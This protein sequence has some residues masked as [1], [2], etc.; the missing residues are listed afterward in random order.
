[1]ANKIQVRR[2][3]KAQLTALGPLAAGEPGYTSDTK[4]LFIGNGAGSNTPV[5]TVTSANITYYVRTD[6]S[7]NNTG[8]AN[9]AAGAFRTINKAISMIP[10]IV[11]HTV[12]INVAAG[13]YA[14]A[15]LI[16]GIVGGGY[17][18]FV[19]TS[20]IIQSFRA[21]RCQRIVV[22]GFTAAIGNDVGFYAADGGAVD[23]TSCIATATSTSYGV[24]IF[25][26][27]A[28]IKNCTISNHSLAI[29]T[30]NS[31]VASRNN[32]GTGNGQGLYAMSASTLHKTGTQ[33]AAA[34]AEN[35]EGGGVIL[36]LAGVIN[37]WGDNNG[38][39]RTFVDAVSNA[40]QNIAAGVTTKML[41][42][43]ERTDSLNEYNPTLSRFVAQ[44]T[45]RYLV[46]ASVTLDMFA[47]DSWLDISIFV[48]GVSRKTI[49]SGMRV[50]SQNAVISLPVYVFAGEYIEI[51]FNAP[52]VGTC[53]SADGTRTF[54]IIQRVA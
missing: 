25:N 24:A 53:G 50:G 35:V 1:M 2:G 45:G 26:Q 17:V 38:D 18:N 21:V 41:F 37:P 54:L 6:G 9:T 15:V 47:L 19:G 49:R 7:D 40:V 36:G 33:P 22:S 32:G 4:E 31:M 3:T 30:F 28:E 42:A 8:L 5:A 23:F 20:A 52:F 39:N 34:I 29:Y 10:Q 11:D 27:I 16:E 48:N 13:T 46:T 43:T 14:E 51:Y 44:Q 12:T